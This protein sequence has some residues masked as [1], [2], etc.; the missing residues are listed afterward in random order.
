MAMPASVATAID[1]ELRRSSGAR[2][3]ALY[4]DMDRAYRQVSEACGFT[5]HGCSDNCCRSRFHHHTI[6]EYLDLQ[7]G[8]ASLTPHRR[9]QVSARAAEALAAPAHRRPPCPLLADERCLLYRHRPMICRLHGIP[10]RLERPD[11][12]VLEGDGCAAFHARCGAA[13]R[14]LDR[15]PFYRQMAALE[16]QLRT[17]ISFS[18]RV[19]LT[20]AEM[21]AAMVSEVGEP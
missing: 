15:T 1:T 13:T 11:G 8:L 2:L 12:T 14:R 18:A 16:K 9:E 7:S 3:H 4:A 17:E 21:I 5:C 19:N 20:V 6:V 10:Y